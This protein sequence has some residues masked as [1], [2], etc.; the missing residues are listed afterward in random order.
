MR[1]YQKELDRIIEENGKNGERKGVGTQKLL[2]E[3][4]TRRLKKLKCRF[5]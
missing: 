2:D 1:Q 4:K 5:K 3:G